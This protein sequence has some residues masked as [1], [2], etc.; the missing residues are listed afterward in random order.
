LFFKKLGA[1]ILNTL[2]NEFGADTHS[3]K[4]C[5]K[6]YREKSNT[7]IDKHQHELSSTSK[8][9]DILNLK[10]PID[11]SKFN[12]MIIDANLSLTENLNNIFFLEFD[13]SKSSI[14]KEKLRMMREINNDCVEREIYFVLNVIL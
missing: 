3:I 9:N 5:L 13:L 7:E 11:N 10:I 12:F 4:E 6:E 8:E 1:S 2:Q 14:N